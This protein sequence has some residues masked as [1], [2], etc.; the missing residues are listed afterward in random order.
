MIQSV[1]WKGYAFSTDKRRLQ[2]KVIHSFL[3]ES[4]WSPGISRDKVQKAI[5]HSLCFGIYKGK[6]Q[7]GFARVISDYAS[8]A[9]L[10]DVFVLLAHRGKGLSKRLMKFILAHPDLQEYRNFLLGTRDAHGLYAQF[11]FKPLPEPARYMVKR[12]A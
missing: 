10:A 1:I 12:K 8:F 2:L 6:E 9:Y 3:K 5:R 11:G 4:Y 7:V